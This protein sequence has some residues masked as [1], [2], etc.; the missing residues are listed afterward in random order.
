[1]A[2]QGQTMPYPD[3]FCPILVLASAVWVIDAA[4]YCQRARE[5]CKHVGLETNR[6]LTLF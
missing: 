1:M 4:I 6:Q 2:M 3:R 5:S